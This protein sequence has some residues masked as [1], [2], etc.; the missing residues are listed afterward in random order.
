[1]IP[2]VEFQHRSDSTAFS[3]A[4]RG[5][6]VVLAS[7]CTGSMRGADQHWMALELMSRSIGWVLT[8]DEIVD[9]L[10]LSGRDRT[11]LTD[12]TTGGN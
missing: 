3:A 4:N 10:G 1:M 11:E 12:A 8:G 2:P 5:Y 7:D 9:R 6:Q